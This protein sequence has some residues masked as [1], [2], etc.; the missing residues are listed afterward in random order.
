MSS[1]KYTDSY[2]LSIT[3]SVSLV[4]WNILIDKLGATETYLQVATLYMKKL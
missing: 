2:F 4:N 1:V 3:G